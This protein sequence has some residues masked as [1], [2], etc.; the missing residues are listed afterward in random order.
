M[1]IVTVGGSGPFL[2]LRKGPLPPFKNQEG[3][4]STFYCIL[5]ICNAAVLT[6]SD[7]VLKSTSVVV[8]TAIGTSRTLF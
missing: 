6:K 3:A 2:L 1:V 5:Q 4:S 7:K 8:S